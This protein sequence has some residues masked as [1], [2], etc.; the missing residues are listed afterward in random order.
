[1]EIADIQALYDFNSWAN[2]R[3][4]AACAPLSGEQFTRDLGS[5]F[6]SVRDTLVHL[7]SGE[8][9]WLERWRGNAPTA[10]PQAADFPD[11][12]TIEQRWAKVDRGLHEFVA[13]LKAGDLTRTLKYRMMSGKE[14]ESPYGQ[15]LHHLA[16]HG[17]YHRGQIA[18]MLRQLGAKPNSTDLIAFYR[19]RAAAP[20]PAS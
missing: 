9:L 18:T 16:N 11:L 7:Y 8:W 10:F 4:R 19:E 1:M 2:E 12:A 13:S 6:R 17:T 3:T 15:M 14:M 5:S 20:A